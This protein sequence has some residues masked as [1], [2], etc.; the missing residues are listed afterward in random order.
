MQSSPEK[1][2][3]VVGTSNCTGEYND[4]GGSLEFSNTACHSCH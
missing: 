1:L 3:E 2:I 4:G